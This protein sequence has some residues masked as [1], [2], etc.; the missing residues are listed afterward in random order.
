MTAT[1]EERLSALESEV[2]QLKVQAADARP[3][4]IGRTRPGFLDTFAGVFA[5][6]PAFEEVVWQAEQEREQE[7]REASREDAA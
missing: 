2:A 4:V 5:H 6:H 1:I 3:G 7:R